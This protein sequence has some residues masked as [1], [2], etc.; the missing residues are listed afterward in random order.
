MHAVNRALEGLPIS[1]PP[2][3]GDI[4]R[5]L[6]RDLVIRYWKES[7]RQSITELKLDPDGKKRKA[8]TILTCHLDLYGGRRREMYSPIDVRAFVEEGHTVTHVLLLIDD[9]YDMLVRLSRPSELYDETAGIKEYIHSQVKEG[10]GAKSA[11]KANQEA[12]WNLEWKTKVL[13]VLLAWRRAEMLMAE[14]VAHQLAAKYMV[15]GVKQSTS[16]IANWLIDSTRDGVY[17]SHPITRPRDFRRENGDWPPDR[18]V[19]ECNELQGR[20]DQLGVTCVMPTAIDELRFERRR[21]DRRYLPQLAT[22]WPIPSKSQSHS[23][24]LYVVSEGDL[25]QPE[26]TNILL[27]KKMQNKALDWTPWL[28]SLVNQIET[29]IPFRDHH[30]VA[31]NPGL[32]VLRPFYETGE[33]SRGVAAEVEHWLALV[34]G[35]ENTRR[36]AV[37]VHFEADVTKLL[38]K[39]SAGQGGLEYQVHRAMV[40]I[41]EERG[42]SRPGMAEPLIQK[43]TKDSSFDNLLDA[44]LIASDHQSKLRSQWP[45]I[46]EEAGLRVLE[47]Q[48]TLGEMPTGAAGIWLVESEDELRKAYPQIASFL[49]KPTTTASAAWKTIGLKILRD[50]RKAT[51]KSGT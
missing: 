19:E 5:Y 4:T 35:G 47:R 25:D 28:G 15:Y 40:A 31:A 39:I 36:R 20:F 45:A 21:A 11:Q 41:L 38:E 32:L 49:R 24:T 30:L 12:I 13:A 6:P 50:A 17:I 10:V 43:L 33:S 14:A 37:F 8:V 48:L 16:A 29:E 1:D 42:Y 46:E 18:V 27:P 3:V 44:G 2:N 23:D 34:E 9:I 51:T 22:R 26:L 7:L